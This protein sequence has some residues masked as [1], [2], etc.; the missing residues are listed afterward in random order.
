MDLAVTAQSSDSIAVNVITDFILA[1]AMQIQCHL[2]NAYHC[3]SLG[4]WQKYSQNTNTT[5]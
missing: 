2:P 5:K 4:L 1:I 3:G